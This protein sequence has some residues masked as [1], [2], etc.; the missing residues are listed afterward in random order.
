MNPLSSILNLFKKKAA[1]SI[2]ANGRW[3]EGLDAFERGK[4]HYAAQP[5]RVRQGVQASKHRLAQP[6]GSKLS[7]NF[8]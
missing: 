6:P 7:L 1:P 4:Q 2:E 5:T 8:R 3:S